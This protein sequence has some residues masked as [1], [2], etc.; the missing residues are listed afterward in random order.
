M[1]LP[2]GEKSILLTKELVTTLGLGYKA[3][4]HSEVKS[5]QAISIDNS[6][7]GSEART[8]GASR[9]RQTKTEHLETVS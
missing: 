9:H 4:Y 5:K 8:R 1:P 6:T 7:L 2:P 3:Q